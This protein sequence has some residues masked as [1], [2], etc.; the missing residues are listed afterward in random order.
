MTAY[1][2]AR[3]FARRLV[4][5]AILCFAAAPAPAPAA[6]DMQGAT[7]VVETFHAALIEIMKK[8]PSMKAGER[9]RLL[10]AEIGRNF[11]IG[12]MTR[13]IAGSSWK[14]ASERERASLAAAFKRMSASVYTA[15]FD[16]YSGQSF[17]TLKTRTGP[18]RT[19]LVETNLR[20][21][22][23]TPVELVYVMKKKKTGWRI[24][25]VILAGG[26]SELA[27]RY[28]E[29]RQVLRKKG[30]EGLIASLDAMAGRMLA[31]D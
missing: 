20:R 14:G 26:I 18:R 2:T 30:I 23:D 6:P 29:S 15:R 13:I 11:D 31:D 5:L 12:F 9:F 27:L 17:K 19:L 21:P 28:S 24:V 1:F 16:G 10:S 22:K 3:T 4:F 7:E 25:D 8:A